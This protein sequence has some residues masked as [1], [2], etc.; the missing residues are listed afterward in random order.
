MNQKHSSMNFHYAIVCSGFPNHY[1]LF[2]VRACRQIQL[3]KLNETQK[4]KKKNQ[5]QLIE[6]QVSETINEK[7]YLRNRV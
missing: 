7:R 3:K 5:T 1:W 2:L 6:N 4:E